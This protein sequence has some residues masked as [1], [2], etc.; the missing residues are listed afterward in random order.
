MNYA[1][2]MSHVR[3]P[4]LKWAP[5]GVNRE[6]LVQHVLSNQRTSEHHRTEARA[7][8]SDRGRTR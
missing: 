1:P 6:M 3:G 8:G 2:N 5:R 7:A 4:S